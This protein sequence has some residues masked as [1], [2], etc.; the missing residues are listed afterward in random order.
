MTRQRA[1]WSGVRI[2]A[3]P[4]DFLFSNTVQTDCGAHPALYSMATAV[5][6]CGKD[7]RGAKLNTHLHLVPRLRMTGAIPLLLYNLNLK[8]PFKDTNKKNGFFLNNNKFH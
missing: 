2:E 5:P 3:G 6:S 7:G 4:R 1:G 8:I